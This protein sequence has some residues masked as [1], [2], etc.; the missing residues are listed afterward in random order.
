MPTPSWI[1]FHAKT[2]EQRAKAALFERPSFVRRLKPGETMTVIHEE[3]LG[4]RPGYD[5]FL[6]T[7]VCASEL[8]VLGRPISSVSILT[9]RESWIFTDYSVVVERWFRGGAAPRQPV[10]PITLTVTLQGGR[11]QTSDGP[12][13]V[14]EFD[15]ALTM[16]QAY[17]FFLK[18][19]P[20]TTSY[21]LNRPVLE[22]GAK[23]KSL[24][25]FRLLPAAL[26]DG[27]MA[28]GT[29]LEDMRND[30][31]QCRTSSSGR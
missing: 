9:A 14:V 6:R 2:D 4:D 22:V 26:V 15:P 11:I 25:T 27:T 12:I 24:V 20:G 13:E 8:S 18:R 7:A 23:V 17:V 10:A 31:A 19:I 3:P 30:A 5:E 28:S 1:A 16:N 29:V 21:Q